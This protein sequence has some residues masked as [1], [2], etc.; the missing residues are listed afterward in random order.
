VT[1]AVETEPSPSSASPRPSR[2][3]TTSLGIL[4]AVFLVAVVVL[5]IVA[6]NQR[7]VRQRDASD[8]QGIEHVASTFAQQL[9][10]YD[11]RRLD[12][13]KTRVLAFAVGKFRDDYDRQFPGLK[14][15][16]TEAQATQVGRPQEVYVSAV[17]ANDAKVIVVSDIESDG[18]AGH[19]TRDNA[20]VL[21][22][23]LKVGG[24]WKVADVAD[25]NFSQ[26]GPAPATTT[27]GK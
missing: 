6:V 1:E 22:T 23:L 26:D 25:L 24:A 7:D 18:K 13:S 20:Y 15:L 2:A 9:L 8:R 19:R 5:S 11:Y 17:D 27:P 16:I 3:L 4:A 12:E 14:A 21:L 10:T